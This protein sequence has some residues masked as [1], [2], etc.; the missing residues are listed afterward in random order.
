[1]RNL[2][3]QSGRGKTV[4]ATTRQ[5]ESMI[6]L[7]EAHARMRLS[8]IVQESDVEEAHR[9]IEAAML[10]SAI[11]PKTG[12]IDYDMIQTGTSARTR[13]LD[14]EKRRELRDIIAGME[15]VSIRFAELF[16]AFRE[17]RPEVGGGWV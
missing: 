14:E 12:L 3:K 8:P 5:L 7:S 17:S 11:D 4:T 10:S 15:K 9:I 16:R 6:R 1:M 13:D 2:G